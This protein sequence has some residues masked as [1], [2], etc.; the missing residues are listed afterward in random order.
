[1]HSPIQTPEGILLID[2]PAGKSSFFA[3][4]LVRKKLSQKK[5]GHTGTLDPFATGLL[6][7]LVGKS[8][9]KQAG[10]FLHHDKEYDAIFS[11]G[12]ATDTYDCVGTTTHESDY[13][14]SL[15]ELKK[16]LQ[17]FQGEYLQEPPMFSAKKIDGTRLYELARRGIS[18]E[19][20]SVKVSINT[21]L[22]HYEYPYV[23]L[24]VQGSKGTYVRSIAHDIGRRLQCWAHVSSLRRVRSGPFFLTQAMP[25]EAFLSLSYETMLE[26]LIRTL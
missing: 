21:T 18:V 23:T 26:K 5:I 9:T 14:P 13:I 16:V 10:A 17:G 11:L 12:R 25:L 20:E 2:K 7:L 24:R 19:R 4:Q 3:V 15:E 6:I 22:V 8:W 1:M